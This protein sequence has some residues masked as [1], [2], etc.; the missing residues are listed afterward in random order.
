MKCSGCERAELEFPGD[1]R[2]RVLLQILKVFE[3][4]NNKAFFPQMLGRGRTEAGK[5]G[6][7]DAS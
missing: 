5:Q 1:M 3:N 4:D 7:R 6:G 2:Y